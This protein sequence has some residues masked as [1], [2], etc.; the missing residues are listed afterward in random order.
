ML[1]SFPY[2]AGNLICYLLFAG[3]MVFIANLSLIFIEHLGVS[4]ESYGFYQ[5]MIMGTF[6]VVSTFGIWMIGQYGPLKTKY[7]GIFFVFLGTCLLLIVSYY[8][9]L[10]IMICSAMVVFTIGVTL[11]CTIYSVEA[12]NI[13]P[14]MRGIAT[15]LSNALR[16]IVIAG[17][18]GVST[19]VFNGSILPIVW[20]ISSVFLVILLLVLGLKFYKPHP[21]KKVSP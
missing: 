2:M 14:N 8:N 18:I 7:T 5:A 9:P 11:A 20:L 16:Y 13:F 21:P 19:L 10:P 3:L 15:G 6:A 17:V 1:I 4:Q 12:V